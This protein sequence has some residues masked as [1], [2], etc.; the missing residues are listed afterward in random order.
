MNKSLADDVVRIVV[1][2]DARGLNRGSTGNCST[3]WHDDTFLITPSGIAARAV[4]PESLVHVR[5]DETGEPSAL[6]VA[7]TRYRASSEWRFHRDIYRTREDVCAIIHVHSTYATSLAC[8][9]RGIPAFHYM[10]AVAGGNDIRCAPYATYGTQE[11]SENV[12][13]AIEGRMACLM[14]NHGMLATGKSLS[15]ALATAIEVESL[16]EQYAI[17]LLL[18]GTKTLSDEEM[19]KVHAKFADYRRLGKSR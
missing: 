13:N 18:G 12:I 16:A 3:R 8:T 1:E 7:S 5:Y 9:G 10:I 19:A 17:S 6:Q 11:L 4:T 15:D 2:L 14:E